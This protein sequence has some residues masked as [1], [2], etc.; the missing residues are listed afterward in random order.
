MPVDDRCGVSAAD[1]VT[2]IPVELT[3]GVS[4]EAVRWVLYIGMVEIGV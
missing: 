1:E 2:A 3:P 4:G